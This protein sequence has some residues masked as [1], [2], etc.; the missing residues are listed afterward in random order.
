MSSPRCVPVDVI[1]APEEPGNPLIHDLQGMALWLQSR[2]DLP[3]Y[4]SHSASIDPPHECSPSLPLLLVLY[5]R[6]PTRCPAFSVSLKPRSSSCLL[7]GADR[8]PVAH[9]SNLPLK[10]GALWVVLSWSL[11][12]SARWVQIKRSSGR[13]TTA[14]PACVRATE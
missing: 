10:P 1:Q 8:V 5:S 14:W 13:G 6:I 11:T 4:A 2:A 3:R 9:R 7:A 12:R